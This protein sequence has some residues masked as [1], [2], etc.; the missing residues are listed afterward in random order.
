MS[1]N[2]TLKVTPCLFACLLFQC[3]ARQSDADAGEGD[4]GEAASVCHSEDHKL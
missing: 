3:G 4:R 2:V 1:L